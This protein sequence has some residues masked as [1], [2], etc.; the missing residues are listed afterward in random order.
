MSNQ[1][2]AS[3]VEIFHP[4]LLGFRPVN[5][6]DYWSWTGGLYFV[7]HNCSWLHTYQ[8]VRAVSFYSLEGDR[9]E[10]FSC[11]IHTEW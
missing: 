7:D 11:T 8:E 4:A 5:V 9:H 3:A 1:T 6:D 10:I 2:L